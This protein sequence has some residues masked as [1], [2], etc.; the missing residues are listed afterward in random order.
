[1]I[2]KWGNKKPVEFNNS[3]INFNGNVATQTYIRDISE[4]KKTELLLK[5]SEEKFR[6][7]TS[8]AMDAILMINHLGLITYWNDA[9]EKNFGYKAEE[10]L[11]KDLH[12]IITPKRLVN[13]Y[14][15]KLMK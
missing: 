4:R 3:T 8:S 14:R 10:V 7:L 5:E 11:Y 12:E 9:S 2:D 1:M 13:D 15:D 6:T